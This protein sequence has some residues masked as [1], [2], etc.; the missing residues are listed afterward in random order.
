MESDLILYTSVLLSILLIHV[1]LS[2]RP[3]FERESRSSDSIFSFT[4]EVRENQGV[5]RGEDNDG[6]EDDSYYA[7]D[8]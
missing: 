1:F 5:V 2:L 3:R 6:G 4:L 8:E 7:V